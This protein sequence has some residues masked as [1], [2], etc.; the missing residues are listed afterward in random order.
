VT[1]AK[2]LHKTPDG[3][4]EEDINLKKIMEGKQADVAMKADDV[5]FIPSSTLKTM[6][7]TPQALLQSAAGAAI[8][9]SIIH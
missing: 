9:T 1:H 8:Y 4:R 2:F 7:T 6:M 5:L 3:L